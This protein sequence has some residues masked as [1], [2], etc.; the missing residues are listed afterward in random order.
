MNEKWACFNVGKEGCMLLLGYRA[1]PKW[2][3]AWLMLIYLM[4]NTCHFMFCLLNE[5]NGIEAMTEYLWEVV[6]MLIVIFEEWAW[7]FSR[8]CDSM[9]EGRNPKGT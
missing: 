5:V 2:G 7:L 3:E 8:K 9:V 4:K 1:N 6:N